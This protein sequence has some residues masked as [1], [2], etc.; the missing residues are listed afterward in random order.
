MEL[1]ETGNLSDLIEEYQ[2]KNKFI[3]EE[4]ILKYSSQLVSVLKYCYDQ[5]I[6]HQDIQPSNILHLKPDTLKLAD[7]GLAEILPNNQDEFDSLEFSGAN[8][9][10]YVSPEV[11]HNEYF[12]FPIDIWSV[13]VIIYQLME[14]ECPFAPSNSNMTLK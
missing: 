2:D 5:R 14:L 4:L 10:N 3:P 11:A 13:G 1:I 6:V 8:S 12:S 9:P 7:F